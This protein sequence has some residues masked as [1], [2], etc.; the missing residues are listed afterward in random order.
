MAET[1]WPQLLSSLSIFRQQ[2]ALE[3][4][5]CEAFS[6]ALTTALIMQHC[7]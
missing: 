3:V 5:M 1:A 7:H 6:C 4:L 2:M